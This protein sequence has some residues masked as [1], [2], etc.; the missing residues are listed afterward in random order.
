MAVTRYSRRTA[1]GNLE[2]HDSAASMNASA[3][4]E[5]S[6]NRAFIFGVLGFIAGGVLT[7]FA[8]I[9]FGGIDWPKWIRFVLVLAGAAVSATVLSILA[10]I[11]MMLISIAFGF[12]VIGFIGWIIW[13]LV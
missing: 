12:G 11:I 6:A 3:R 4:S 10:D 5:E 13:K 8:I 9:H 7:W 1:G 2:Y